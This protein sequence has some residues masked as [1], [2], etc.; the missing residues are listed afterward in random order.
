MSSVGPFCFGDSPLAAACGH[1]REFAHQSC[2]FETVASS[3]NLAI[4]ITFS[5]IVCRARAVTSYVET[6]GYGRRL[7]RC[8]D[9]PG[10]TW[11]WTAG[12]PMG[13]NPN[14]DRDGWLEGL[15][16]PKTC[17]QRKNAVGFD[18]KPGATSTWADV[19]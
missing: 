10:A 7:V 9:L 5:R 6:V 8:Y 11:T 3:S 13:Q 14:H 4:G 1:C 2:V 18:R 16:G 17:G 15:D 19:D 12:W